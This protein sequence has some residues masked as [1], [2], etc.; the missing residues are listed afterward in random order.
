MIIYFQIQ[1]VLRS[2]RLE[3]YCSIIEAF[4]SRLRSSPIRIFFVMGLNVIIDSAL[5]ELAGFTLFLHRQDG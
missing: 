5:C 1:R 3:K 2:L 4:E